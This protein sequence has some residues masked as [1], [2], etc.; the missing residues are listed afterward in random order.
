MIVAARSILALASTDAATLAD[1][2]ASVN[3][4]APP[5]VP[6]AGDAPRCA[7]GHG[8]RG[9]AGGVDYIKNV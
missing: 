7:P 6:D 8:R 2:G 4:A 3:A 9:E 5:R 1:P